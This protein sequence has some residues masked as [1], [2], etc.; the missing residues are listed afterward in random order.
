MSASVAA[1]AIV[2]FCSSESC[3]DFSWN[4]RRGRAEHDLV[5]VAQDVLAHP[6][7]AQERAVQAAEIAEQEAPVGLADDLRV[8]LGDDAVEDLQ[9][10]VGV[11]ADGVD[12][13]RARTRAAG[14]CR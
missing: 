11:A 6:L 1:G 8:L 9:R 2:T 12:R 13:R 5:A 7:A 3:A 14:R 10:V 4:V